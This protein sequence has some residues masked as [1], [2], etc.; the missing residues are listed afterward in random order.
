MHNENNSLK[1]VESRKNVFSY[2]DVVSA[3]ILR[4]V[5]EPD[6]PIHFRPAISD[7]LDDSKSVNCR[8]NKSL[9]WSCKNKISN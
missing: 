2:R 7:P 6:R 1:N 9:S 3:S 5:P 8:R 4:P